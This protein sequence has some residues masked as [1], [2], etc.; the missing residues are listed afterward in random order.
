M[1]RNI[2]ICFLAV[3]TGSAGLKAQSTVLSEVR[4]NYM[5]V[6]KNIL[7]AAEKMPESDY[8]FKPTPDVRSF[9]QLVDHVAE[10]QSLICGIVSGAAGRGGASPKTSKQ[11]VMAEL[12][13][14][15]DSCDS[16]YEG[17]TESEG[18][19]I[20]KTPVGDASKFGVLIF[21]AIHDNETYGTMAVYLRLKGIVPPSSEESASRGR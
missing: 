20:V 12:K 9:G 10:V 19:T 8:S 7:K 4:G 16:V 6:K 3:L 13:A 15:F 5:G 21:N 1:N 11:D 18:K 17:M 14:S 2:L